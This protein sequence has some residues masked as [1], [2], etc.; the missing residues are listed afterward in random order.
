MTI[1][2]MELRLEKWKRFVWFSLGASVTFLLTTAADARLVPHPP[3]D[4]PNFARLLLWVLI[5]FASVVPAAL[6]T[7]GQDW[8]KTPISLRLNTIFGFLAASWIVMISFGRH[9]QVLEAM[10]GDIALLILIVGIILAGMYF[11]LR[12]RLETAPEAMFP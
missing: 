7:L 12:N 5:Q 11:Y 10:P 1:E 4:G 2:Q 8:K 9:L 3:G 6:L